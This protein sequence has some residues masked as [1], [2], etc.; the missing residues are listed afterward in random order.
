MMTMT[1][2]IFVFDHITK[3]TIIDSAMEIN[4]L[5]WDIVEANHEKFRQMYP[6]SQVNFVIDDYNFL[7]S[8]PLN[9]DRD[10][11]AWEDGRMT[12][13]DFSNKWY[14]GSLEINMPENIETCEYSGL[15]SIE[16]YIK[17]IQINF[18]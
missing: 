8:P 13:K 7:M 12:W 6:D 16:S 5:T 15:P 10:E 11:L 2:K 1:I 9:Q 4:S 14:K 18:I 3:E 17:Y